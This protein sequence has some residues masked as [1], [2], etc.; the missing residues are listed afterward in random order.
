MPRKK[1]DRPSCHICDAQ[2]KSLGRLYCSRSCAMKNRIR[3]RD[4][5]WNRFWSKVRMPDDPYDCWEWIG[6]LNTT[7]YGAFGR[8]GRSDGVMGAHRFSFFTFD[9]FLAD[10]QEVCHRCNNR[11]CVN[12]LHLYAGSRSDN[13]KQAWTD[14]TGKVPDRWRPGQFI[15]NPHTRR[16]RDVPP[17]PPSL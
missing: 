1:I 6:A 13:M 14:G 12:P 9:G 4:D 3:P 2:C 16:S 8:G 11:K 7:G 10:G 17:A 15:R 5:P